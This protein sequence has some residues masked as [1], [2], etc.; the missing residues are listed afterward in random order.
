MDDII[1]AAREGDLSEVQRL[2]GQDAG[3]LNARSEINRWTPLIVASVEGHVEVVRWLL[4][5]N[6]AMHE[7]NV[8]GFTALFV[9]SCNGHTAVVRLSWRGGPIQA[10]PATVVSLL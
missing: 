2:V 1:E 10:L 6:A 7:G 3:L 8:F 4:D 9:A 5:Q